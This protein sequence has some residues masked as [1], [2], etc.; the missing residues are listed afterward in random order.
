L[1][2]IFNIL[3]ERLGQAIRKEILLVFAV[4]ILGVHKVRIHAKK[5]KYDLWVRFRMLQ[6]Y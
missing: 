1:F 5:L 6:Q 3:N 2:I 4:F